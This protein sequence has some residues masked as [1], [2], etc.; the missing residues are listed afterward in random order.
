MIILK[1][2]LSFLNFIFTI[3][4]IVKDVCPYWP[5]IRVG[6]LEV[7]RKESGRDKGLIFPPPIPSGKGRG[8]FLAIKLHQHTRMGTVI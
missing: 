3:V 7:W 6:R 5:L 1:I 2:F 8:L 4:Y